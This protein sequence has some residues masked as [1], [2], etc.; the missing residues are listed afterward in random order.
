MNL[1]S[2]IFCTK[3]VIA[4]QNFN[5]QMEM[6]RYINSMLYDVLYI[7]KIQYMKILRISGF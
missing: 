1:L 4:T 2:R 6:Y 5:S 7:K 3:D